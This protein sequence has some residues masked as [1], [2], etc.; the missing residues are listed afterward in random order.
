M[1]AVLRIQKGRYAPTFE[2]RQIP[3]MMSDF[4]QGKY[5]VAAGLVDQERDNI[6]YAFYIMGLAAKA[7]IGEVEETQS[8]IV[9]ILAKGPDYAQ[10]ASA[11][12]DH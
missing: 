1:A 6:P 5:D 3:Q 2:L 10:N 7:H 8:L 11:V 4:S 9:D 12:L